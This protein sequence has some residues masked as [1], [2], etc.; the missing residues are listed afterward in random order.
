MDDVFDNQLCGKCKHHKI[1]DDGVI[2]CA[3]EDSECFGCAV[4][5]D[6]CADYEEERSSYGIKCNVL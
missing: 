5:R 3:N 1:A 4:C 2:I 6:C